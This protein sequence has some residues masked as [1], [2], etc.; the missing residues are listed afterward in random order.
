MIKFLYN[1]LLNV[2]L[3]SVIAL[4]V[5]G[6]SFIVWV[7]NFSQFAQDEKIRSIYKELVVASGQV[8]NALP[9]SIVDEDIDNAYNDGTKIVIYTGLVKHTSNWD[10]VALVLGHE[11]AH[12][13]LGHLLEQPPFMT[14]PGMGDN[15][16][17]AVLE[18]NAD[19]MG[20]FYMMK[21]GYN[22]CAGRE[23]YRYWQHNNGNYIGLDHPTYSYR[24]DELNVN[25]GG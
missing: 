10:E 7:Q 22:I 9:L 23:L 13:M 8:Q 2:L 16:E 20:A 12:G 11:I 14:V 15:D 6:I 4:A 3:L 17:I 1:L 5:A 18:A 24:Y 25:C 19:K 21:A